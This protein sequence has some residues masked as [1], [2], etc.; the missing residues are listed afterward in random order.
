MALM[1]PAAFGVVCLG[2]VALR[3][4]ETP[5]QRNLQA[6]QPVVLLRTWWTVVR[7]P[8]FLAYSALATAAYGGLFTFLAASSFGFIKVLGLTKTQYGL[9]MFS[10]SLVYIAGTVLCR[11]LLARYGLRHTVARAAVLT[12]SGGTLMGLLAMAGVRSPWAIMLPFYLFMLGHGVHPPCSQ[13][14]AVGPF[15]QAAGAASELNGFVMMLAAYA[16]GGWLGT[17]MD[18]TV[19]PL[20]YG[21]WFWS[22]LVTL[23]A[24]TL[25]QKYGEPGRR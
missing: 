23:S 8:T 5:A 25:V 10:I 6:L 17:H 13:S 19:F 18:G 22:V 7:N 9:V 21:M 12:I 15:P 20:A 4:K 16:M 24:W 2:L 11:F 3:F 1:A 14:A